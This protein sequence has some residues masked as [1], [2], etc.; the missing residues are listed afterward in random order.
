MRASHP[1]ESVFFWLGSILLPRKGSPQV[2]V[3]RGFSF[4][5]MFLDYKGIEYYGL[6]PPGELNCFL[7]LKDGR[8]DNGLIPK[9]SQSFS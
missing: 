7:P 8:P 6:Y 9:K 1:G 3:L 4:L 5:T 2:V